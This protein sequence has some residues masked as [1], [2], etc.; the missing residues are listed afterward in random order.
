MNLAILRAEGSNDALGTLRIALDH[1]VDR[2]W[3]IG[4]EMGDGQ[5]HLASGFSIVVADVASPKELL[6][7]IRKF[8]SNCKDLDLA[9]SGKSGL[10]GELSIGISVGDT[11]QFSASL[12]FTPSD[13]SL[14]SELGLRLSVSAYPTSDEVS[15]EG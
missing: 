6:A 7:D 2:N 11:A 3:Q 9:F 4:D 10:T 13:L 8:L 5:I 12:D 15:A 1:R 14:M